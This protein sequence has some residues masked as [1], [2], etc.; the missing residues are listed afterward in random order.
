VQPALTAV[1]AFT[2][3]FVEGQWSAA[4]YIAEIFDP[5]APF[6]TFGGS[7]AYT[8]NIDWGDGTTS[9]QQGDG[10]GGPLPNFFDDNHLYT[11]ESPPNGFT[12]TVTLQ[13]PGLPTFTV[14][15]TAIVTDPPVAG[16]T[17]SSGLDPGFG[18][19]GTVTTDFPGTTPG[20][21]SA[22]VVQV[23][24]WDQKIVVAGGATA[25]VDQLGNPIY[26]FAVARYNPDG[27]LDS[28]FG[29]NGLVTIPSNDAGAGFLA[30]QPDG[31]IIVAG[32]FAIPNYSPSSPPMP[33]QFITTG[34]TI[35]RLN[36][37][38]SLDDSFG[39]GGSEIKDFTLNNLVLEPDG[40]V[41]VAGNSTVDYS[42]LVARL[43]S[44]GSLD[45]S[46]GTGGEEIGLS[47]NLA[48]QPDGKILLLGGY[49]TG[50]GL[51]SND[52]EA[53]TEGFT[54]TRLDANGN[55]DTS[56]GAG[57]TSVIDLG[58]GFL[59]ADFLGGGN[60]AV[61][62]DG[63]IVVGGTFFTS[64]SV[65]YANGEN[66]FVVARLDQDGN[67]D[68][69]FGTG[70]IQ[71][72][73]GGLESGMALEPD[74]KIVLVGTLQGNFSDN[75]SPAAVVRL[76]SDGN[77]DTSFGNYGERTDFFPVSADQLIEGIGSGASSVAVQ[78]DGNIV[79]AGNTTTSSWAVARLLGS[80]TQGPIG[81]YTV[82]ADVGASSGVQTVAMFSDP[83]GAESLADYSADISWGDGGRTQGT[84]SGPDANGN[85]T[86]QGS[87]TYATAGSFPIT[88]TIHHDS[89]ADATG[90]SNAN[91]HGD[92]LTVT[93]GFTF[94]LLEGTWSPSYTLAMVADPS[95]PSAD[96]ADFYGATID[97]GDG[98]TSLNS[99][100]YS[101]L[102]QFQ[103]A[104]QF[105]HQYMEESPPN[106]F[107]ITVT[108]DAPGLPTTTDTAIVTDPA[109][110]GPTLS[111]AGFDPSFGQGGTVTTD[112]PGT[113]SSGEYPIA[114]Y[115][116]LFGGYGPS[117]TV[118]QV[119]PWDQKIVVA[120]SAPTSADQFGN[121]TTYE[122]VVARY[123]PDGTLDSSFGENGVVSMPAENKVD[124][125]AI[126][127][128]G[129]ILVG[130]S[131]TVLRLN[132]D[133]SLD[134]SF[135]YGI[136]GFPAESLAFQPDGKIIVA[137]PNNNVYQ[138]ARLNSDGSLD[139]SFGTGGE[140]QTNLA[141]GLVGKSQ[142]TSLSA[143]LAV[144]PD[145]KILVCGS[146]NGFAVTRLDANGDL[147]TSFGTDGTSI[148]QV[149]STVP[150]IGE[151][152]FPFWQV[153]NSVAVQPDGKIIVAGNAIAS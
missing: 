113:V 62:S 94:H 29:D 104:V 76:D 65:E 152:P 9:S 51:S 13:A 136:S 127:P 111:S 133:G 114:G 83:G 60:L 57:G 24:P 18:Q 125:L 75:S 69:S 96:V 35:T 134:N 44:D 33:G 14:T 38:G 46:F 3:H 153:A 120:G 149:G 20:S 87:Y 118:V 72:I 39:I 28:S 105:E 48:L 137:S 103:A 45:D 41:V 84:I 16:P 132:S 79:I 99:L 52:V 31:K 77:P 88:V 90:I 107:T 126:Q 81:G 115:Y 93:G 56:F 63:K 40:K 92:N 49:T 36:S 129:K 82:T 80:G 119:Q 15:D 122:V 121:V 145:G 106:G 140:Q 1:G 67:L 123:N 147:D 130:G 23:Q 73:E 10:S 135:S 74:G 8:A 12:I 151:Y 78:A 116:G 150:G 91:V 17:V 110:V 70:G 21:A 55:L 42:P 53:G 32:N 37:D 128:D 100:N 6:G 108:V 4:H 58:S 95:D 97:W 117:P 59:P 143:G 146:D 139:T 43:N 101:D 2:Y 71:S 66:D 47:G 61:Q 22:S 109:V 19:G 30:I 34:S 68:P 25:G 98:T 7:D 102:P 124:S 11:E 131:A 5:D 144:Q 27:S 50:G 89:A 64:D 138:V 142:E 86:V 26:E 148:I 54:V 112:F 141:A 85:F